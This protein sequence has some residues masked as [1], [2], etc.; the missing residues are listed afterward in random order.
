MAGVVPGGAAGT[1]SAGTVTPGTVTPGTAQPAGPA[2]RRMA[3]IA[4]VSVAVAC[5][6]AAAGA[7]LPIGGVGLALAVLGVCLA[8]GAVRG[9]TRRSARVLAPG[10]DVLVLTVVTCAGL[11]AVYLGG[12]ADGGRLVDGARLLPLVV[13]GL[14]VLWPEPNVLRYCLL[15]DG[16][17]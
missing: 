17:T 12:W 11:F 7:W 2:A 3:G 10:K 15:L 1:V 14:T 6:C 5:W 8:A 13:L 16:A 9:A 4:S